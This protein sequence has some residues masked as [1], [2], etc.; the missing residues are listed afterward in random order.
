MVHIGT[1]GLLYTDQSHLIP[2]RP[3]YSG[4]RNVRV[5]LSYTQTNLT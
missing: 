5:L 4:G 3:P 1:H 2:A